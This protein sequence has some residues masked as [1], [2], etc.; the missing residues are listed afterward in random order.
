VRSPARCFV[1]AHGPLP[2]PL[3][4]IVSGVNQASIP[5]WDRFFL[6]F[7]RRLLQQCSL[8]II[9]ETGL[10]AIVAAIPKTAIRRRAEFYDRG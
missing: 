10:T 6:K 9:K 5:M 8:I 3:P 2:D 1:D 7:S 4:N